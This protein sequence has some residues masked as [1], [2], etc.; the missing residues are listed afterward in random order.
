M[1]SGDS[2]EAILSDDDDYVPKQGRNARR[3]AKRIGAPI[4]TTHEE[5]SSE[6]GITML[7]QYRRCVSSLYK[8]P[9]HFRAVV[10]SK[11][12]WTSLVS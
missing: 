2:S 7:L 9:P 10:G 4:L 3:Q 12:I 1:G 11:I 5:L 6:V 8:W